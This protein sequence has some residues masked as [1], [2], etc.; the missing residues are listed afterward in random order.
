[1]K[2]QAFF[3]SKVKSK[4]LKCRLLQFLIS[5]LSLSFLSDPV[6]YNIMYICIATYLN[7]IMVKSKQHCLT[8]TASKKK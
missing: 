7:K 8:N 3:S 1:M 4:K 2:N 6:P 5:A